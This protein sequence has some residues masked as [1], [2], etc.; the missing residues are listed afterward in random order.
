MSEWKEVK[1]GENYL[2]GD[3]SRVGDT[4]R[5]R[6]EYVPG[7]LTHILY[8]KELRSMRYTVDFGATAN[9]NNRIDE[10][11]LIKRAEGYE[12]GDTSPIIASIFKAARILR[13]RGVHVDLEKEMPRSGAPDYWITLRALHDCLWCKV[14]GSN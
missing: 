4:V 5:V 9:A 10:L 7:K 2:S 11:T 13:A 14:R 1:S 3:T 8:N 6:N 12:T